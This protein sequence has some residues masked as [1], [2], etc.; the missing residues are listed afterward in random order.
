[1]SKNAVVTCK[2]QMKIMHNGCE[3]SAQQF[4]QIVNRY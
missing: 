1:M 2:K 3:N 4:W